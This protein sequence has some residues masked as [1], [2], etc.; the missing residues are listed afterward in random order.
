MIEGSAAEVHADRYRK[1]FTSF[2]HACLLLF[3]GLSQ[4]RSL[5]Q[6]YAA[7]GAC[8]GLLALS[9][10][11]VSDDPTDERVGVSFSQ[12][13]AS[14]T[15]R[16]SDFLAGV[17]AV[18]AARVRALGGAAAARVPAD[19]QIVDGTF[20]RLSLKL[21]TWL[22]ERDP[23]DIP[24]VR[25]HLQ[26]APADDLPT[27]LR[28]T[29]SHTA[30]RHVFD[31]RLADPAGPPP[32]WIGQT[33]VLDLG[34][35]GHRRFARLFAA[36]VHLVSRLHSQ[37]GFVVRTDHPVQ[38]SLPHLSPA[39]IQIHTDQQIILGSPENTAGAV[40]PDLRL[41]TA[42]VLPVPKAAG[43]RAHPVLYRLITDRWD[44]SATEIVQIY[45][46]RW[47]IELF[48]RW[49]KRHVHLLR[50]LGYSQA[51]L[52]LTVWLSL[53]VH[54]LTV[55]AAH[56]LGLTRRSPTVLARCAAVVARLTRHD[57]A[58]V[59]PDGYQLAFGESPVPCGASP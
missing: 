45:L 4:G 41:V 26:Y 53:I 15:S 42:T 57:F 5:T 50:V 32:S 16:P 29:D 2:A 47:Q 58:D 9:G 34:Y 18:L 3:H 31:A 46:W 22:P 30:E 33:L 37:A 48:F 23:N 12:L 27:V 20:L 54:L 25:L 52:E 6:S 38:P 13:A 19:V 1:H 44:L 8:A 56:A 55:L 21:A 40:L 10:L 7:F 35:Y 51:A 59:D 36:G 49:L 39:P 14:N 43:P 17:V 11:A 28:V 24:G